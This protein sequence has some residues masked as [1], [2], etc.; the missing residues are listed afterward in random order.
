MYLG[1][2]IGGRE[3]YSGSSC[4]KHIDRLIKER[5]KL[6]MVC[7]PYIDNHYIRFLLKESRR[8]RVM[9]ISSKASARKLK[10]LNKV[11]LG[12]DAAVFS[13]IYIAFLFIFHRYWAMFPIL[14]SVPLIM[15]VV[16]LFYSSGMR[17]EVKIIRDK[18]VHEKMY[19][20][21]RG[22]I[23][24]SANL[25]FSGTHLNVEHIDILDGGGDDVDRRIKELRKHFMEL[26][27]LG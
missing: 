16:L 7:T 12:R 2:P 23:T 17:I 24:G 25:T 10:G 4:Y 13:F 8:K 19:I 14:F 22:A 9:L 1:D 21:D 27:N 18:F 15:A 6:L 5:S 11:G 3:M 26:W 20:N